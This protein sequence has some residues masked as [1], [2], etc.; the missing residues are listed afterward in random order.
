MSVVATI[1]HRLEPTE[2]VEYT[3]LGITAIEIPHSTS[4]FR[5]LT[6]TNSWLGLQYMWH[7]HV[8]AL[9]PHFTS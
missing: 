2:G 9:I 8:V 1:M 4:L 6:T 7:I 3:T 5:W